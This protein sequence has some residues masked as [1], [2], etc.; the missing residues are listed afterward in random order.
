MTT[1]RNLQ[2]AKD[3][4]DHELPGVLDFGTRQEPKKEF[5]RFWAIYHRLD[6]LWKRISE[7]QV[8]ETSGS[9]MR[10]R[11]D[12]FA[13]I[14]IENMGDIYRLIE[15]DD[16]FLPD[17]LERQIFIREL[18]QL[19][20]QCMEMVDSQ[21]LDAAKMYFYAKFPLSS[22][23]Y[24]NLSDL[25][26]ELERELLYEDSSVFVSEGRFRAFMIEQQKRLVDS[27]LRD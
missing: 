22:F 2:R 23:E 17:N 16:L 7:E 27:N 19:I 18:V 20:E 11:L 4:Y 12:V 3:E 6:E 14:L 5:L 21:R 10:I 24:D 8:A 9:K 13:T 1:P 26:A 15:S 25:W